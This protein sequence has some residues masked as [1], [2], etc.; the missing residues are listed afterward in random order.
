LKAK[1][2]RE[3]MGHNFMEKYSSSP[4]LIIMNA[5]SAFLKSQSKNKINPK[6]KFQKITKIKRRN[7]MSRK[8]ERI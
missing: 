6:G 5:K 8:R 4:S 7:M 3:R 1:D 2:E